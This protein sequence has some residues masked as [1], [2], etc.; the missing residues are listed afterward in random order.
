M[1]LL[2]QKRR[3]RLT[4]EIWSILAF[5]QSYRSRAAGIISETSRNV[6]RIL[7]HFLSVEINK[8]EPKAR[9]EAYGVLGASAFAPVSS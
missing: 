6:F 5:R 2:F 1:Q 9:V 4:T 3:G 7:D 8:H